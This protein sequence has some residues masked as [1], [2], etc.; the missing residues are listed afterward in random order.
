LL[1]DIYKY[2]TTWY[3]DGTTLQQLPVGSDRI[4]ALAEMI[5]VTDTADKM[6]ATWADLLP[7]VTHEWGINLASGYHWHTIMKDGV[8][9][10]T[11]GKCVV[12]YRTPSIR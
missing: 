12:N 10:R 1:D 9:V 11:F 8:V 7:G 6:V 4:P 3:R 5:I 2:R